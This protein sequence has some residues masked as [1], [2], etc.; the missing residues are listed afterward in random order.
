VKNLY[1][2]ILLLI[3][4]VSFSQYELRITNNITPIYPTIDGDTLST[5]RDSMIIFEAVVTNN[6]DTIKNAIFSWDFDNGIIPPEINKDSVTRIYEEG[7]GYRVKLKVTKDADEW[8]TILPIKIAMEPNYS[9]T[10]VDLPEEQDG[11]CLGSTAPLIGKAYPEI[12]KDEPIYEIIGE[13]YNFF[14][15]NNNFNSQLTF[16]EFSLDANFLSGNIDSI[17]LKIIHADMG[18]LQIK[19][20]CE[21]GN[22][23]ILKDFD[24]TNHLLLGDTA[25]NKPYQYYWSA[26]ASETVNSITTAIDNIIPTSAYLPN[27]SFDNLIGCKLNGK[28]TIEINDN[29]ELDSGFVYSWNIIFQEDVLPNIWTFKDTL[30][31]YKEINDVIYGTYWSGTN[32][33]ASH[34]IKIGDTISASTNVRPKVYDNNRYDFHVINNWGCPQDTFAM[35]MVEKISFTATPESGEAKLEVILENTT[36]WANEKDWDFGDKSPTI[37]VIDTDTISHKYLEK[38]DYKVILIVTDNSVCSDTDTITINVT[39]EPS[40]L[41]NIPNMFSPDGDGTNDIYKFS[42][43]SLKGMKEFELNIYNRWGQK[44]YETNEMEEAINTGWDGKN[45]I[46][47]RCSPGIYFY[48]IKAKGKDQ[49]PKNKDDKYNERGTIHLFR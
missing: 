38:G 35:L 6:I 19:L 37:L 16:D 28:W 23:I 32:A 12:W 27:Q 45:L 1:I 41:N 25:N 8:F 4:F 29:Q 21:K 47:L 24:V 13:P 46:G 10:K 3:P 5:C 2:I 43:E 7:G 40:K 33:G 44:V 9:K 34:A 22:S 48:V 11:I 14:E 18:D 31:N 20:S 26:S 15:F 36:T 39:V 49:D 17:G 42:K 30:V